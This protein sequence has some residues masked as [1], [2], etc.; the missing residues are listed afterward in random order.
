LYKFANKKNREDVIA[1]RWPKACLSCGVDIPES[2]HPRHAVIGE[3]YVDKKTTRG[4]R[5]HTQV[6]VK[7]PGLFYICEECALEIETAF[8]D[9]P[10][11]LQKLVETL[12]EGPWMEFIEVEKT[13]HVRLPEGQFKEKLESANPDGLFKKKKNPMV[14]LRGA[15]ES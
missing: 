3:F 7:L 5:R 12:H 14:R 2:L 8:K 15:M 1:L 13:G 6:L 10:E 4:D 9:P 11:D